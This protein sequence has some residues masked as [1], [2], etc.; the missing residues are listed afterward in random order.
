M[1]NFCNYLQ[2]N[3]TIKKLRNYQC[4]HVRDVD[5]FSEYNTHNGRPFIHDVRRMDINWD[6]CRMSM[7]NRSVSGSFGDEARGFIA[8][9]EG[10]NRHQIFEGWGILHLPWRDGR[11]AGRRSQ[12]VPYRTESCHLWVRSV[13]YCYCYCFCFCLFVC[14]TFIKVKI[15]WWWSALTFVLL[16]FQDDI[17]WFCWIICNIFKML[18]II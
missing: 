10:A 14:G 1:T 17:N 9:D 7:S 3:N 5:K 8:S 12:N 13:M 16:C 6:G 4:M 11:H 15:S 2:T 18:L